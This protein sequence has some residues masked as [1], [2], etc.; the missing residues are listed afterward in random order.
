MRIS[1]LLLALLLGAIAAADPPRTIELPADTVQD[2]IRGGLLGQ[3]LGDLN[4]L[5]HEMKYIAEATGRDGKTYTDNYGDGYAYGM[6]V[7]AYTDCS[8][9]HHDTFPLIGE[10]AFQPDGIVA[11]QATFHWIM[12]SKS[13]HYEA[14][15]PPQEGRCEDV[16]TVSQAP[17][18]R[19]SLSCP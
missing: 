18:P 5:K 6:W 1:T 2:K 11:G 13:D 15:N 12:I 3:I 14:C 17:T 9:T 7:Q 16:V 19:S 4:G 8:G 10:K